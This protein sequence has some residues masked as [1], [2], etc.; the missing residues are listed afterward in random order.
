[1]V[2]RKPPDQWLEFIPIN[3]SLLGCELGGYQSYNSQRRLHS[4]VL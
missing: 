4:Q 2:A 1:M 3:A